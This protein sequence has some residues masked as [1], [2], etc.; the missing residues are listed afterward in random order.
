MMHLTFIEPFSTYFRECL[1]HKT[2]Q[3]IF[4]A[5]KFHSFRFIISSFEDM[6]F[7]DPIQ[8]HAEHSSKVTNVIIRM[9]FNRFPNLFL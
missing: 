9:F 5:I 3:E 1:R 6:T 8:F 2:R 7:K 4:L